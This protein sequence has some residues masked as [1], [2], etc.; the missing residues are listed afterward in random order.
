MRWGFADRL[1]VLLNILIALY[2]SA[3]AEI[4]ENAV[5]EYMA[6]V[7]SA[8]PPFSILKLKSIQVRT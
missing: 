4:T 2:N 1:T 6:L 7:C 5:N 8:Y 3:Y